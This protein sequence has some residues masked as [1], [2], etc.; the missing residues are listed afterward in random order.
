MRGTDSRAPLASPLDADLRGLPPL[1]IHVGS[2]EIL[3]SDSTEL[4]A[5][6]KAA[7]VDV[8]QHVWHFAASFVPESR[9]AIARIGAFVQESL[10]E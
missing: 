7:G 6:A 5:R 9:Q 8:M 4:A 2:D 1:L 3:L 10:P